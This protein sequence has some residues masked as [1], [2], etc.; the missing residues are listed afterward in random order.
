MKKT[1][2]AFVCVALC[3]S[4]SVFRK[5]SSGV[6]DV[7][8][9]MSSVNTAELDVSPT[10]IYFNYLPTKQDC[11]TGLKNVIN[12]AVTDALKEHR[13][14][15][16][17]GMQWDALTKKHGKVRKVTVSGYPAKYKNFKPAN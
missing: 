15:V 7:Q 4:C 1:L 17:V 14:D 13:A 8:T 10:K 9:S 16:L 12:N 3:C 5:S 11:K 2:L 6:L